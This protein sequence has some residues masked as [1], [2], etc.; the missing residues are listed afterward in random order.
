MTS[1]QSNVRRPSAMIGHPLPSAASIFL[2]GSLP[3][4]PGACQRATNLQGQVSM[5]R[6]QGWAA[7]I[8]RCRGASTLLCILF[9]SPKKPVPIFIG[10]FH[11]FSVQNKQTC[12]RMPQP[13]NVLLQTVFVVDVFRSLGDNFG[14]AKWNTNVPKLSPSD[15][16]MKCSNGRMGLRL[17]L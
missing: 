10:W 5:F 3:P 16:V 2:F 13:Q 1:L 9:S 15:C 6:F 8:F 11:L 7:R 4:P 17:F 14:A 12:H